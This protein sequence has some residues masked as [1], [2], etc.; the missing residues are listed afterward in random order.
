MPSEFTL[1]IDGKDFGQQRNFEAWG[2]ATEYLEERTG[3]LIVGEI[4]REHCE[5]HHKFVGCILAE[6]FLEIFEEFRRKDFGR[7]QCEVCVDWKAW[8]ENS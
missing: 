4:Y 5:I 3:T 1:K 6:D 8:Q 7:C 2:N